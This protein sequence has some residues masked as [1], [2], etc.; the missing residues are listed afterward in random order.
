MAYVG[1]VVKI[2]VHVLKEANVVDVVVKVPVVNDLQ[3]VDIVRKDKG[4]D[5][6]NDL[7][8]DYQIN[9]HIIIENVIMVEIDCKD[10]GHFEDY[11]F[12]AIVINNL[13][14]VGNYIVE[15]VKV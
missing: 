13:V 4:I 14:M 10:D 8:T 7:G 6:T 3:E 2:H 9:I 15:K 5:E 1:L 11:D 12:K